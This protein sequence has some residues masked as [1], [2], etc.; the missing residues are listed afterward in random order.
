MHR[1]DI[2]AMGNLQNRIYAEQIRVIYGQIPK[3]VLVGTATALL[4]S[5]TIW[6]GINQFYMVTRYA[7]TILIAVASGIP[8]LAFRA[9]NDVLSVGALKCL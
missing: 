1:G 6:N 9:K 8:Y 5:I 2:Y 4:F 7:L 3:S